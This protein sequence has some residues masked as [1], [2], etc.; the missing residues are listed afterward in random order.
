MMFW[1]SAWVFPGGHIEVDEGLDEGS[2][3][4]FQEEVGI[5]VETNVTMGRN[6][7]TYTYKG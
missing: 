2:L 4:E 7:R 6:E 3:R 1:P 5:K